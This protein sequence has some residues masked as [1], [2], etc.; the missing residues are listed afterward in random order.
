MK[1]LHSND[2]EEVIFEALRQKRPSRRCWIRRS[3]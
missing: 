1:L 2:F 3:P